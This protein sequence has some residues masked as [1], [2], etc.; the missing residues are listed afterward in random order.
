MERDRNYITDEPYEFLRENHP[1]A[2]LH[3]DNTQHGAN[4]KYHLEGNVFT[5]SLLVYSNMRARLREH[6]RLPLSVTNLYLLGALLHDYGKVN[7]Q[8][9]TECGEFIRFK[10]HEGYGFF[11]TSKILKDYYNQIECEHLTEWHLRAVLYGIANHG[12]FLHNQN[13]DIPKFDEMM[14]GTS[15][16]SATYLKELMIADKL[17]RIS[18]EEARLSEKFTIPD[19]NEYFTLPNA[20]QN[21]EDCHHN[22]K[23]KKLVMLI[24][25]PGSGK[26]TYRDKHFPVHYPISRDAL[27]MES[28]IQNGVSNYN[29]AWNLAD[30]K[31]MDKKL[32]TEAARAFKLEDNI[33]IDMTNLSKK[34][35]RKWLTL[36]QQHKFST[37]AYV[38]ATDVK[39]CK[40]R[41]NQDTNK[42]VPSSA[43]ENMAKRFTF[44]LKNE[45]DTVNIVV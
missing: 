30:Q 15:K 11:S 29:E 20:Q 34:S 35:R 37:H 23:G 4:S 45:F 24:G 3:M 19:I 41:R 26:T 9:Y 17:G 21:S 1:Q 5:H 44:P 43:I 12:L 33:I 27:I 14:R 7:T 25:L 38:F 10:G 40:E 13:L 31:E 8:E 36:A 2:L 42:Y 6:Y 39:T 18:T 22:Y 32:M 28:G 16:I